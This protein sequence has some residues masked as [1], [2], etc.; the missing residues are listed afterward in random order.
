MISLHGIFF[1]NG[2]IFTTSGA[3][4]TGNQYT[5]IIDCINSAI[6]HAGRCW[7]VLQRERERKR[8]Q[9]RREKSFTLA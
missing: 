4:E 6:G 1:I 5:K 9:E 2:P 7:T 8:L 3:W